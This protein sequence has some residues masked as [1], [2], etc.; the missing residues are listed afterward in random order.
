MKLAYGYVNDKL[1]LG[2]L[3][4]VIPAQAGIQEMPWV[5]QHSFGKA[6]WIPAFAGMTGWAQATHSSLNRYRI[7]QGL[8]HTHATLM[9]V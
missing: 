6:L 2:N 7:F 5:G 4:T 8:R 9:L 3:T 1:N